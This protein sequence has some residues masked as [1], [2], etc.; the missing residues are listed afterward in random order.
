MIVTIVAVIV[1]VVVVIIIIIVFQLIVDHCFVSQFNSLSAHLA[2]L[3]IC[4]TLRAHFCKNNNNVLPLLFCY[5]CD[6]NALIGQRLQL[7]FSLLWPIGNGGKLR[8]S[9][10][11]N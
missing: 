1:A 5:C 7:T 11:A 8:K 10:Q 2:C 6:L 4:L 9:E 3:F